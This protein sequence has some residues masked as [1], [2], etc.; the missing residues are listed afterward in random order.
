MIIISNLL[1]QDLERAE[2]N[3]Q[4]RGPGRCEVFFDTV[5]LF[6]EETLVPRNAEPE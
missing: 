4:V 5:F 2:L 6:W 3:F 1:A